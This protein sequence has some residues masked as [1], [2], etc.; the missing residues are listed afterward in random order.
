MP[1]IER[2]LSPTCSSP[3]LQSMLGKGTKRQ[4]K[5]TKRQGKRVKEKKTT[6]QP[7][8]SYF[9]QANPLQDTHSSDKFCRSGPKDMI[10]NSAMLFPVPR[11][12][13]RSQGRKLANSCSLLKFRHTLLL[14]NHFWSYFLKLPGKKKVTL[15][16]L[17]FNIMAK[18]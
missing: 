15:I 3:H 14:N 2:T 1:L 8:M 10:T 17:K 18:R 13:W 6:P 5:G 16:F 11:A 9:C 12:P 7:A 4:G